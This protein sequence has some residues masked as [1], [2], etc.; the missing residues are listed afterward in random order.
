MPFIDPD[1]SGTT[2]LRIFAVE[3]IG[4]IIVFG[5]LAIF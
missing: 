5:L 1:R 3:F 4:I 2:F